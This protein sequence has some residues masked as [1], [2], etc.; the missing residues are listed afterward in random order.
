LTTE[1]TILLTGFKSLY[2]YQGH[3]KEKNKEA[4]KQ[5]IGKKREA[6]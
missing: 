6:E 4:E 3:G 1:N 2:E 5:W